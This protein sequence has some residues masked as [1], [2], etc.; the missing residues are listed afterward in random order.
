MPET[1]PRIF[2]AYSRKDGEPFAKA[3]RERLAAEFG[4]DAIWRDRE[5]MEGGVGWWQQITEALE[6]VTY[7][8]LVATPQAMASPIVTKEWRYAR[9]QGV[10]VYPVQVPTAP[11]NLPEWMDKSIDLPDAPLDFENLPRWMSAAHFHDLK[12]DYETL[13]GY[14]RSKCDL[15]RVPFMAPDL[16]K[17]FVPRPA[18]F[19]R[20]K[21][22]LID[23]E[24]GDAVAITTALQGAGGFGKT[25]LA[26][27]LCH[28]EDVQTAFDEGVIWITLGEVPDVKAA[29]TTAYAALTGERPAFA[30][31]EDGANSLAERLG[32]DNDVLLVI[33]D[34]W[35]PSHLRPFLRGGKRCARLIT[36]RNQ[37]IVI[38]AGSEIVHVDEM[39]TPQAADMLMGG[40]D[41][42]GERVAYEA[43]AARL[44]EWALL[45]EIANGMLRERIALG[46]IPERALEW[47]NRA[48][49]KRGVAGIRREDEDARKRSAADVLA[50]SFDL[51]RADEQAHLYELAVFREDT[52]IPFTSI[53]CLWRL[54]DFDTEDLLLKFNRLAFFTRFDAERGAIRLHDVVREVLAAKA[55]QVVALHVRLIEGW[56]N[57]FDLPDRYAWANVGYHLV[58]AGWQDRLR[59]LI[60][61]YRWLIAKF[62]QT[63]ANATAAEAARLQDDEAARLIRNAIEMSVHILNH[64]PDKFFSQLTGRLSEHCQK[65]G[66]ASMFDSVPQPAL[67]P[68]TPSSEQAGGSLIRVLDGHRDA[69]NCCCFSKNGARALSASR[70]N[71]LRLWDVA[72][73]KTLTEFVGHTGD[74]LSCVFFSDDLYALSA[75]ADRTLRLWDITTG[76]CLRAFEGHGDVVN[77][78][79]IS[80]DWSQALSASADRTLRLWNIGTGE[81]LNVFKGHRGVINSC[82]LSPNGAYALSA[83]ADSTLR[84]WDVTTGKTVQEIAGQ[85]GEILNCAFSPDGRHALLAFNDGSLRMWDVIRD[86]TGHPKTR[87]MVLSQTP[88]ALLGHRDAVT[89][90]V[91]S[92][93]NTRARSASRD[94]TL[95]LW[96]VTTGDCLKVFEGHQSGVNSCSFHPAGERCLSASADRTLRLWDIASGKAPQPYESHDAAVFDCAFSPNGKWVISSSFDNKLI[97]WDVA[98]SRIRQTLAGHSSEVYGC[99][100]SPDGLRCLSAS[101]DSTMRVWDPATG[102]S[103]RTYRRDGEQFTCCAFSPDGLYGLGAWGRDIHLWNVNTSE[104]ASVLHGYSAPVFE[105]AFSPDGAYV[106]IASADH[107]LRLWDITSGQHLRTYVGH[108]DAV[109]SCAFSPKGKRIVSASLDNSVCLWDVVSGQSL[110]TFWG[111]SAAVWDCAFSPDGKHILSVSADQTLRL[112]D[113]NFGNCLHIFFAESPLQCCAWSPTGD[114]IVVGDKVGRVILFRVKL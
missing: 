46:N 41:A 111:H 87:G 56:G 105:C 97:L 23:G 85:H 91:F 72:S 32:D 22:Q 104:S 42:L 113:V 82:A 80:P 83:S 59:E 107:T 95:R 50:A 6:T 20:L 27:A 64:D 26:T 63:D 81:C 14:L 9:Q 29:L 1:K 16:P 31:I 101:A 94:N 96:D 3:L 84:L 92:K 108:R 60:L 76:E 39:T 35:Q 47:V 106:I 21:A 77:D 62:E 66:I 69:V 11:D 100:F 53:A 37:Q 88:R 40:I 98:T 19:E 52:D 43:L 51:L 7:M 24:R 65:T 13:L 70:D 99:A 61:N 44:G 73:G 109:T 34:V 58:E 90:C 75:S 114:M 86:D 8:V 48:L 30:T 33:D 49:E 79:D 5:G 93:D 38:D 102:K 89:S 78:C 74:V 2:I 25:T 15:P 103:L 45:C 17:H 67:L 57:L 112:W 55:G 71:A 36:T 18:E 68:L 4:D 54:D 110:Y 12:H 10:C 28:D